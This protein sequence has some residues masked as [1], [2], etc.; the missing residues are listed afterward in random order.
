MLPIHAAF[1]LLWMLFPPNRAR[2]SPPR[3]GHRSRRSSRPPT[4]KTGSAPRREARW[5]EQMCQA[6]WAG[7]TWL[8]CPGWT[9]R[10][11]LRHGACAVD[12]G[13]LTRPAM[14]EQGI[15]DGPR[16]PADRSGKA[17]PLAA[18][19]AAPPGVLATAT[20]AVLVS[21][22]AP[23]SEPGTPP[24][25]PAVEGRRAPPRSPERATGDPAYQQSPFE[26]PTNRRPAA[27]W[28]MSGKTASG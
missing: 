26:Q 10:R 4:R 6:G 19:P 7:P 25:T 15:V 2:R 24:H 5:G 17:A 18:E 28:E 27:Q 11:A 20:V 22:H 13:S 9:Q 1:L 23:S 8:L 16:Q 12:N 3:D 21:A 14:F